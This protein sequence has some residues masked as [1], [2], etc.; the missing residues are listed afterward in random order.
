MK[1]RTMTCLALAAVVVLSGC[2][3]AIAGEATGPTAVARSSSASP[4]PPGLDV[5]DNP[6][7]LYSPRRGGP[8]LGVGR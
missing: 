7:S 8:E 4:L 6:T 1:R 3:T 5:G 2:G